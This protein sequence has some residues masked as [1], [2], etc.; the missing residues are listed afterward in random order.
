MLAAALVHDQDIREHF[1][2]ICWIGV[3]PEPNVRDLQSSL[4]LQICSQPLDAAL[5]DDSA[6]IC[7]LQKAARGLRILL[8]IDD[9]CSPDQI[10]TLNCLDPST[11][12]RIMVT[13]DLQGLIADMPEYM[14]GLLELDDA[15]QLL[16]AVAGQ[17]HAVP[18]S[19][20]L[21]AL[22][23]AAQR[24]AFG[25]E[26]MKSWNI[27]Q[28]SKGGSARFTDWLHDEHSEDWNKMIN[29]KFTD[30]LGDGALPDDVLRRYLIQDHRFL[31]GF[32]V[33]LA[34]MIAEAPSL[35]DRIPGAQFLGLMTGKENT[36]F[37]RA[38]QAPGVTEEQ[39]TTTPDTKVTQL[40]DQQMRHAAKSWDGCCIR[41]WLCWLWRS[42]RTKAGQS[43]SLVRVK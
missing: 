18:P 3:G 16:L 4:H 31:D 42:G 23:A 43:A 19:L 34:S 37:E 11:A 26:A 8:V 39:R 13:T 28:Q 40:F 20:I 9:A 2:K 6:C 5:E 12:S 33:L 25:A 32:V 35:K 38:F 24:D 1:H 27:Y 29:N 30:Q 22:V 15:V 21:V 17:K 36:Y 10:S 14:L 7:A 41:C